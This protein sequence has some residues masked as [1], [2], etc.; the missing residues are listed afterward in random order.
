[1]K[2]GKIIVWIVVVVLIIWAITAGV[3]KNKQAATHEPIK[4]GFIG[5]LTGEVANIGQN[6]KAGVEIA[7]KE[8]NDA[9]GING[10]PLEVIY[11]DGKCAGKESSSAA[12]K[13]INI[14]KVPVILGGA[15]S[16]ETMAFVQAAEQAK[17]TVLSYCSSAPA[18]TKAGDYIFRNYP[19]DS[20]QGKYAAEYIYNQLGKKKVAVFYSKDD[21]GTGIKDVFIGAFK[22]LGG[23]VTAEEGFDK[24]AKD[25]RSPLSKIK[26]SNPELIYFLG[27]AETIPGIKQLKELGINLPLFGG[28][29]WDDSKIWTEAGAAGEG[30]MYTS[31]ASNPNDAFKAAMKAKV[32]NDEIVGCTPTAYDGIHL[33]SEVMKKVGTDSTLIKDELYKTTY[34]GGVS[35]KVISFD[36]NGDLKSADYKINVVKNGKAEAIK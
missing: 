7:V 26:S 19:S 34:T 27:Y 4:I 33:L 10:R 12:S 29:G 13:L 30:V 32:G 17:T 8:V 9:G 15:C 18:V 25:F 16:G 35:S 28:D 3:S 21:W 20:F 24:V 23:T 14:D 1:M 5:P 2:A 22:Q 36:V 6:A 11:E 31:V